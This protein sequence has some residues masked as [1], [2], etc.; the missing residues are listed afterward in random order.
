MSRKAR[1]ALE[2]GSDIVEF[3]I[4]HLE[5]PRPVEIMEGLSPFSDRCVLTVRSKDQGGGFRGGDEE[6]I[7]LLVEICAMMKPA[8]VDVEF[9]TAKR[10]DRLIRRVGRMTGQMILSWHDFQGTPDSAQLVKRY[11]EM[12]K[13]S[14]DGGIVKMVTFANEPEDNMRILS[15]YGMR[16]SRKKKPVA[17]CMGERGMFSRVLSFYAGSPIAYSALP[18][19]RVAP[20]QLSIVEM[21]ELIRIIG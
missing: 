9:D 4:D 15:L 8:F 1:S 5:D 2:F 12:R 20:G 14:S 10:F 11:D 18:G 19:E 6:R 7:G 3:R 21:R 17:F 13:G 16:A